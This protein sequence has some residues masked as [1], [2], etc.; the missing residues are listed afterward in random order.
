VASEAYRCKN[1]GKE[2]TREQIWGGGKYCTRQCAV[3]GRW[4]KP[5]LYG[6]ILTRSKAFIEAAKLCQQGLSQAE[7]A[8]L[9]GLCARMVSDWFEQ[10]GTDAILENRVCVHCGKTLNG[11][12]YRSNRKYCSES[13]VS[14]AAYLRKCP[15]P[16]N[17]KFDPDLRA[18]ALDL[19]W[20]GLE[21]RLIA[22]YLSI[23]EGT[24]YCWIHDFGHLRKRQ[25]SPEALALLPVEVRLWAA[26]SPREWQKIPRQNALPGENGIVHLVCGTRHGRGEINQLAS[27]VADLLRHNPCNGETYAFC[28]Q[29]KEQI[30]TF[31]WYNNVFR[32]AKFPKSKG[33]YIWPDTS[34]GQEIQVRENEL[35]YLL[36]LQKKT[37]KKPE[38]V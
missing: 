8:R 10:Y 14:K 18:K 36:T 20:G 5:V 7:A 34:I 35:E 37:G 3:D 32:F 38:F 2:L 17:R 33:G 26:K 21:G 25:R 29:A 13:C 28:S 4:G 11:M 9:L 22:D 19:Y 27:V 23:A 12:N 31:R 15:I 24:V 30:L 1:C 6:K 16:T